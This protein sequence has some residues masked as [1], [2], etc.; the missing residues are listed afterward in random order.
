MDID[1]VELGRDIGFAIATLKAFMEPNGVSSMQ[2][3]EAIERLENLPLIAELAKGG[4]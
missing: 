3:K 1:S 2:I 4:K